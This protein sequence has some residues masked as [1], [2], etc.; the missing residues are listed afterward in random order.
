MASASSIAEV[1]GPIKQRLANAYISQLIRLED[2]P[3][4]PLDLPEN[5]AGELRDVLRR[6][7]DAYQGGGGKDPIGDFTF[8]NE[9]A[10]KIISTIFS[11]YDSVCRMMEPWEEE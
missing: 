11:L 2:G 3:S 1:D 6:L 4:M 5:L 9:E 8:D 7:R 10:R